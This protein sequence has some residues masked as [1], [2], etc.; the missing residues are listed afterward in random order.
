[1]SARKVL[2]IIFQAILIPAA[3]IALVISILSYADVTLPLE[4][5]RKQFIKKASELTG[6]EVNIDG[7]VQLAISFYP[8][9]VVEKL[10]IANN[11][12]W[13]QDKILSVGEVRVQLAL[14][15]ILL[16]Q[17]E[18]LEVTTSSIRINLEQAKDGRQSWTSFVQSLDKKHQPANDGDD[19]R[20]RTESITQTN[21]LWIEKFS[22][23][24]LYI[25]YLD[26]HLGRKFTGKIDQLVISTQDRN[27]LIASL[28]GTLN[29]IPYSFEATS[30]LLRN[31]PN[32]QPWQA[33]LKGKIANS[34]VNLQIKLGAVNKIPKGSVKLEVKEADIGR[35]LSWLGIID[36]LDTA[37]K[38]L[39]L[40]AF[41][42]G[43]NLNE[44][45]D[46][47]CLKVQL[48]DGYLNL[49]DPA[50]DNKQTIHFSKAE[51]ESYTNQPVTLLLDGKINEEPVIVSLSSNPLSAFF[52][53][54]D[55]VTLNLDARLV[56]ARIKLNGNIALPITEKSF[57][58]DANI[59]G[60]RLDQWNKVIKQKMPPYGPYRIKGQLRIQEKGFQLK[61]TRVVI[62]ESDL[63]GELNIDTRGDSVIWDLNLVSEKFQIRDFDVEGYSLFQ[64]LS[65]DSLDTVKTKTD[66]NTWERLKGKDGLKR[67]QLERL[68]P[69]K[70]DIRLE[71]RKVTSGD[72][73]LGDGSLHLRLTED[74]ISFKKLHLNLPG[75]TIDGLFSVKSIDQG[76]DGRLKLDM[77]RF[78]YGVLY[79][80]IKPE[81]PA[82]G[83]LS[84]KIDL[85]LRGKNLAYGFNQA[86]GKMDFALWPESID[87]S[88]LNLWSVN[89]LLAILPKLKKEKSVLNCGVALLDIEDGKLSEELLFIDSTN[90]WMRGNLKANFQEETVSLALFPKSKTAR[91]FA[92]RSP[93]RI[94]GTFDE[95]RTK[96]KPFD[97]IGAYFSF[98]TSP[99]HVPFRRL[100]GS[101]VPADASNLCGQ[102]VDREYLRTLLK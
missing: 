81:S 47:I 72:D 24:G 46:Q 5:L 36:G 16:G 49:H 53:D 6:H 37:S 89:L 30:D 76:I 14:L 60:K 95:L 7:Q 48:N 55:N 32:N 31:I 101:K 12:G 11:P 28:A 56:D 58:I 79:R 3:L 54:P 73:L 99:L 82:E 39:K 75:G 92:L 22:L 40:D 78:D 70:A 17:L 100:M 96:I 1:M 25:N 97:I 10:Y 57:I 13:S 83:L 9:L 87:A 15:P 35:T 33:N 38:E 19:S 61:H 88:P 62:G 18:F 43:S 44:I 98:I 69:I 41:L 27:H 50:D 68:T 91:L 84:A 64:R 90:V 21:K 34:P 29:D 65:T 2:A 51:F 77:D 66:V 85:N 4:S 94:R 26:Q 86:N 23:T 20:T 59:E 52:K 63:G 102:M 80:Y 45:L 93:I 8:T 71:A 74:A 42:S 67:H